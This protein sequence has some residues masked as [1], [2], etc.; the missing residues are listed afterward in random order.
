MSK[1]V[2]IMI[3][4]PFWLTKSSLG[5]EQSRQFPQLDSKETVDI[6]VVG[7]GLIGNF[8]AYWLSEMGISVV[9]LEKDLL[10][11]GS[12]GRNTGFILPGTVEHFNRSMTLHGKEKALA[13]WK[14][15]ERNF[16]QMLG[17]IKDESIDCDLQENG[18]LIVASS[19]QEDIELKESFV[20]LSASGIQ[21]DLLTSSELEKKFKSDQFFG[22]LKTKVGAGIQPVKLVNALSKILSSRN[23]KI[24]ENSPVLDICEYESNSLQIVTE[25][26]TVDCAMAVLATNAYTSQVISG[27]DDLIFPF[28][29]QA[30]V[31]EPFPSSIFDEVVYANYGFE[32]WRQLRDGRLMIGGFREKDGQK[33]EGFSTEVNSEL[34]HGLYDYFYQL[35]PKV[36]RVPISHAW[37]GTM[38]FSKDGLPIVGNT[39]MPHCFVC[40]GFTGHGLGFASA[41][42]ELTAQVMVNGKGDAS[43]LFHISRFD[44]G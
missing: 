25:G 15:T 13:I 16:D 36:E 35:F 10:A 5:F 27:F 40:G 11:S 20:H 1:N 26:G 23:I 12:S 31:T 24:Y 44:G 2:Q 9:L 28:Q 18:S 19:K 32:Y 37:S 30:F 7:G 33:G 4:K 8:I 3:N 21:V 42:G 38:G 34:I 43:E 17:I 39:K 14:F 41:I 22:A 29:G 6:C